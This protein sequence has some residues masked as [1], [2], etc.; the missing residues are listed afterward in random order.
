MNDV[1]S[2]SELLSEPTGINLAKLAA[3]YSDGIILGA[4][5]VAPELVEYSKNSGLPVLP[6]NAEALQS[7]SYIEDYNS[8]YDNL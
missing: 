8:F 4:E 1:W 5:D 3:S 2:P 7:G 6:F